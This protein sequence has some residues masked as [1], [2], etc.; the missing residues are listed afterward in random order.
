MESDGDDCFSETEAEVVDQPVM[1]ML[2]Y[3]IDRIENRYLI[4]AI[5]GAEITLLPSL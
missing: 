3:Y 2:I 1:V 5:Y 4:K